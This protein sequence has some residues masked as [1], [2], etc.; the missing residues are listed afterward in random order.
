VSIIND[1]I[2]AIDR[3]EVTALVQL[4]PSAA[5]DTVDHCTLLDV[6][7]RL[8]WKVYHFYGSI[9]YRTNRSQSFSV[10]VVQSKSIGVDCSVLQGFVFRTTRAHL[11]HRGRRRCFH[12]HLTPSVINCAA[13]YLAFEIGAHHVDSS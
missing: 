3:G 11:L 6:L 7:R 13:A 12:T 9:S 10:D 1:I 5:F 4:D 2:R 8:R